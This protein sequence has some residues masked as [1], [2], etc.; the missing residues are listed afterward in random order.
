MSVRMSDVSR[1]QLVPCLSRQTMRTVVLLLASMRGAQPADATRASS[2]TPLNCSNTHIHYERTNAGPV[3]SLNQRGKA[4][5]RT[6][7]K[8]SSMLTTM[9]LSTWWQTR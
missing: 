5:Q 2:C 6:C 7:T 8:V 1:S 4:R 9:A 3:E